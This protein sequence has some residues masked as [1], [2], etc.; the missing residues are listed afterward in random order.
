ML[1][2]EIQVAILSIKLYSRGAVARS[3]G[4][5]SKVPAWCNSSD[6]GL[7]HAQRHA[8]SLITL[9]LKVVGKILA[10]PS[11]ADMRVLFGKHFLLQILKIVNEIKRLFI[12]F[13]TSSLIWK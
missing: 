2:K 13:S 11:V 4:W 1:A 6:V 5:P 3:V 10:V 8:I 12:N 9:R 7:N